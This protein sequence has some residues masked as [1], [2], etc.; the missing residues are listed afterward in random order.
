M[1]VGRFIIKDRITLLDMG[2]CDKSLQAAKAAVKES[3]AA[4]HLK[5][6]VRTLCT[7]WSS[8]YI[9]KRDLRRVDKL[10]LAAGYQSGKTE[11]EYDPDWLLNL[12]SWLSVY[13]GGKLAHEIAT[14]MTSAEAAKTAKDIGRKE[15]MNYIKLWRI[16]HDPEDILHELTE[17]IK[18]L[19]NSEEEE[20]KLS[21]P[22]AKISFGDILKKAY[23]A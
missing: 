17:D 6:I 13:L 11:S 12:T 9:M 4:M 22:A 14:G 8:F 23:Q 21:A 15:A 5:K 19:S 1:K 18:K 7:K 10:L 2:E 16:H 20:I 3:E